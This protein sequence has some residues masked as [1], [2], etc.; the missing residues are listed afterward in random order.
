MEPNGSKWTRTGLATDKEKF[1]GDS[2]SLKKLRNVGT[3]LENTAKIRDLQAEYEGS[4][5]FTRS[6]LFNDLAR[7]PDFI[8]TNGLLYKF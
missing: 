4:I 3:A 7:G 6:S 2:Q 5:P 1:R 8:L